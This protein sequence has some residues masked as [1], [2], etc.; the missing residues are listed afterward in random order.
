MLSILQTQKIF[1]KT[2]QTPQE[3]LID[4]EAKKHPEID[5]IRIVTNNFCSIRYGNALLS[6]DCRIALEEAINRI[7]NVGKN[8]VVH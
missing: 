2:D 1:R 3:F 7:Q 8:E 5:A 4:I 6:A